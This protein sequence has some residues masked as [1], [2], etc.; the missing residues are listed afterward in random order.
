ML[1]IP[2]FAR[3]TRAPQTAGHDPNDPVRG[4]L[5]T[6]RGG[7][8]SQRESELTCALSLTELSSA[9]AAERQP[10]ERE[11]EIASRRAYEIRGGGDIKVVPSARR[12]GTNGPKCSRNLP[13]R[14]ELFFTPPSRPRERES[15]KDRASERFIGEDG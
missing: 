6:L 4:G 3:Q 2:P 10:R 5:R 13:V 11:N 7:C 1:V 12:G 9:T 8:H 14:G 15:K